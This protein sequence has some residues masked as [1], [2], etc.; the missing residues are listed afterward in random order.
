MQQAW[1]WRQEGEV[2][3]CRDDLYFTGIGRACRAQREAWR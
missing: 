3:I 1:D 2:Q